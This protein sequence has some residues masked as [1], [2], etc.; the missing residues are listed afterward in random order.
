MPTVRIHT[1]DELVI[2]KNTPDRNRRGRTVALTIGGAAS[3]FGIAEV[4]A[5]ASAAKL[6]EPTRN[7]AMN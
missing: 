2:G 7:V 3:A 6:S 5:R 4:S 1:G